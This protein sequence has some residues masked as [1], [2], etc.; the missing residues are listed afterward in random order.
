MK[1]APLY[2]QVHAAGQ[3]YSSSAA[4]YSRMG[5]LVRKTKV[6]SDG[7][8]TFGIEGF[9]LAALPGVRKG[10]AAAGSG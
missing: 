2:A 10:E 5:W 8:G 1:E 3:S 6:G 9:P 4:T 7:I